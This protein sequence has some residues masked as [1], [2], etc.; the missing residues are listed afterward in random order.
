MKRKL[1]IISDCITGENPV[2]TL[3]KIKE[4]G[5]DCF[6][7]GYTD[8]ETVKALKEKADVLGLEFQFI[9]APFRGINSMWLEG[10]GYKEIYDGMIQAIDSASEFGVPIVICHVSSGWECP[11]IN[12]LGL[13]RYD[14]LVEYAK[15]HNVIIAFENLRK[16][17]N[18]AYFC[19]RYE[20]NDNVRFCYDCGHEHGYTKSVQFMDIFCHRA[21]CTHIHDNLG[22][23]WD[24]IGDPDLHLLPFD[25]N[26]DYEKMMRKLDEYDYSGSL[27][28][29]VNNGNPKYN[30]LSTEEFLATCYERIKKISEM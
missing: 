6:F 10:D 8:S 30:V 20:N 9:H 22:R 19:D 1:G 21:I 26:L 16:I 13:S 15:E 24:K 7:T 18:I 25:G 5:F 23:G 17:G 12:D 11:E 2:S 27:M 29:E 14:A 28:L 4:A 3:D